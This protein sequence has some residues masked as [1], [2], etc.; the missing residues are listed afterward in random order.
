MVGSVVFPETHPPHGAQQVGPQCRPHPGGRTN[1]FRATDQGFE[2]VL[3]TAITGRMTATSECTRV[4]SALF[5]MPKHT[6]AAT[7][8]KKSI[9]VSGCEGVARRVGMSQPQFKM[10]RFAL[11]GQVLPLDVQVHSSPRILPPWILC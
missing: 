4:V 9:R 2:S 1:P 3:P 8:E 5:P 10:A 6:A 7:T 11:H